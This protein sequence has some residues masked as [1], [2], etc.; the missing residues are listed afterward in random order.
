MSHLPPQRAIRTRIALFCLLALPAL[1]L[2]PAGAQPQDFLTQEDEHSLARDAIEF[3][4]GV[5]RLERGGDRV[6]PLC[7][8]VGPRWQH[9]GTQR[10]CGNPPPPE[11]QPAITRFTLDRTF[12]GVRNLGLD[13]QQWQG[14]QE[15]RPAATDLQRRIGGS[16][17]YQIDANA[18]RWHFNSANLPAEVRT[19]IPGAAVAVHFGRNFSDDLRPKLF[20]PQKHLL[21]EASIAVPRAALTGHA[22]TG[23]SMAVGLVLP[24]ISGKERGLTMIVSV[25]HPNPKGPAET[26]RSDQRV[27]FGSARLGA[28]SRYVV[29]VANRQKAA[30]W[31]SP[32]RFAFR[33]T[34]ESVRNLIQDA[35]ARADP[36]GHDKDPY[37]PARIGEARIA[38]V[39]VRNEY[40]SLDRGNA[41][42]EVIVDYLRLQRESAP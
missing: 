16:F 7:L 40:S 14:V 11:L 20:E 2:L 35:N 15:S 34:R 33:L 31:P 24:T 38:G 8:K 25:F 41:D 39:T 1:A 32:E 42:A 26:I 28:G 5:F 29:A 3:H 19:P 18:V 12:L 6:T 30:P 4:P 21:V 17:S 13:T 22:H 37:D 27:N 23:V 9:I 10:D 36:G